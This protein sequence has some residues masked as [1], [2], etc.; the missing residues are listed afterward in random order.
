MRSLLT[1]SA[2]VLPESVVNDAWL[3]IEDGTIH[4]FGT[5]GDGL[6]QHSEHHDL[7]GALLA[8]AMMDIHV[9]F[10]YSHDSI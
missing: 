1:A 3:L 4:S 2:V 10:L 8:P 7:P 6:P 5:R 9:I